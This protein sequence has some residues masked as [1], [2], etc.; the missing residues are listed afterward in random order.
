MASGGCIRN[1]QEWLPDH[2]V[3]LTEIKRE[4]VRLDY[5]TERLQVACQQVRDER[6]KRKEELNRAVQDVQFRN[7]DSKEKRITDDFDTLQVKNKK[8]S[9]SK[10]NGG[11]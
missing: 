11:N 7:S 6:S 5:V 9:I 3:N 1:G 4:M 10:R 2:L 8:L